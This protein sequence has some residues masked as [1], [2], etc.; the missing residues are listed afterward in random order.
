MNQREFSGKQ[1]DLQVWP[2]YGNMNLD[3]E[4]WLENFQKKKNE[5]IHSGDWENAYFS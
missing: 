5:I 3:C 2:N 4:N 1:R